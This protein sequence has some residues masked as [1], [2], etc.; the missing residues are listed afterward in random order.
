MF[1]ILFIYLL[2]ILPIA[3]TPEIKDIITTPIKNAL[4]TPMFSYTSLPNKVA[5]SCDKDKNKNNAILNRNIDNTNT[6]KLS[7]LDDVFFIILFFNYKVK[8]TNFLIPEQS[9]MLKNVKH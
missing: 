1:I 8:V 2:N 6:E 9:R 3:L 5:F 4:N 7:N